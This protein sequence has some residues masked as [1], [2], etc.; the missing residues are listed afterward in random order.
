MPLLKTTRLPRLVA[1]TDPRQKMDKVQPIHPVQVAIGLK[2]G[3]KNKRSGKRL[4]YIKATSYVFKLSR[5]IGL[6][7]VNKGENTLNT[8]SNIQLLLAETTL[9]TLVKLFKST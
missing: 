5:F 8:V 1:L 7:V 6:K 3:D 9:S 2:D 4:G